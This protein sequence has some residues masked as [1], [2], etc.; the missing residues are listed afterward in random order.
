METVLTASRTEECIAV[1]ETVDVAAAR[2]AA[3]DLTRRLAF[4]AEPAARLALVVTEAATN[5]LKHAGHGEV[6]L[7]TVMGSTPAAVAVRGIEMLAIDDGAGMDDAQ[8][9]MADGNSTAGTYGVGLGAIRR[10]SDEFDLYSWPGRGTVLRAVLW[11]TPGVRQDWQCGLVCLPL[12]GERQCGDAGWA[13][14]IDDGLLLVLADGLGHGDAAAEAADA[15]VQVM[16]DMTAASRVLPPAE[17]AQRMHGALQKT[18]GAAVAIAGVDVQAGRVCYAGV[19]N[20]ACCTSL[21]GQ[22]RHLVSVNG[23][24]GHNLRKVQQFETPWQEGMLLILHSDGLTSRWSLDAYPGLEQSH[25]AVIA[26]VLYRDFYRGRDD[27]SV[28]VLRRG[29]AG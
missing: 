23:I 4:A 7:R 1:N 21:E 8:A 22:R 19:G 10:Q 16:T 15:A 20:I 3:A 25:A 29:E 18:R 17:L 13:A 2:R 27:V 5:I 28:M 9:A 24:V 12:P 11:E 14:T 6:L 26:A